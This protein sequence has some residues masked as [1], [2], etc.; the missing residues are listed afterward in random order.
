MKLY[1]ARHGQTE[2]NARD[3]VLGRT[4]LPL[5]DTGRA[6]A[7]L[8]A[9]RITNCNINLILSSPLLR[10]RETAACAAR[11]AGCPIEV[12]ER[13]IE[14]D[15]GR[16]EG[17]DRRDPEFLAAKRQ[18][19]VRYPGGE[20]M[21]QTAHRV[22]SLLDELPGRYPGKT[23]LFVTHNGICR[24]I[25]TYFHDVPNDDFVSFSLENCG[26]REYDL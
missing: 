4:D 14:Q 18:S 22:Y 20:S 6:Q 10:A 1:V 3:V 13:L 24:I 7:E 17:V 9:Q 2:W 21:F 26:L 11:G 16:F 12:E 19:A 8:L 25:E 15:F 5:N 23:V